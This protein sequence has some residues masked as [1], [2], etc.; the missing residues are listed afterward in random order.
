MRLSK[1]EFGQQVATAYQHLYDLVYLRSHGL[2]DLFIPDAT[3]QR[4]RKAWLLHDILLNV[5]EELDPGSHAPVF[6]REWRRYRLLTLRY[7]DGLDPQT[8]A[9]ELAISRRHFYREHDAALEAIAT[10]LWDRYVQRPNQVRWTQSVAPLMENDE[11]LLLVR[12]EAARL[13]QVDSQSLLPDVVARTVEMI[14]EMTKE[15]AIRFE[16]I[17]RKP[18]TRIGVERTI[19]RQILLGILSYQVE[20]L[21][22]GVIRIVEAWNDGHVDVTLASQGERTPNRTGGTEAEIQLSMLDELATMQQATIRSTQNDAGLLTFTLTF[23]GGSSRSVLVVDDNED[24]LELFGRY[25][26]AHHYQIVPTQSSAEAIQLA[27]HCQ[28][29]AVILDLM[30]PERDGWDVLQTLVNQPNT[31][32]IPIVICTVLAAKSLAFALG[33][34]AFLEKPVT[35]HKLM[36][37]LQRLQPT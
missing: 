16:L 23:P 26:H 30:L 21:A 13:H 3:M 18:P 33:A 27:Q 22:C 5:L 4:K 2:T 12:E 6:S 37:T 11:R 7:T 36:E 31:R 17:L 28:P 14:G 29:D 35:E 9:N 19:L 32:H 34:T 8:V 24:V 25:L 20:Q 1:D 10:I 15:K